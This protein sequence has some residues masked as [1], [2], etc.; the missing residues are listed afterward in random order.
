LPPESAS[1]RNPYREWIGAQ[2]RADFFGYITPDDPK[3]GAELAWRDASISHV[4]NGIYG[5]MFVAAML[6]ASYVKKD[7]EDII[8]TGMSQIPEK[9][10]L[11]E[12]IKIVLDWR[13]EGITWEDAINR[14]HEKYDEKNM[15]H[16]THTISN[17]I[18]VCI[19][20]LYGECD[21]EKSIG[22][23]VTAG[24][25]TDCNCATVGSIIGFVLGSKALPEKWTNPLNNRLKSGGILYFTRGSKILLALS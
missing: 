20:L 12:G 14:V 24:F 4:K 21:F 10:R 7:I 6:S 1:Y 15:H 8:R 17:A 18:I 9:S 16:W 5:E 3:K 19:G 2:I 23:A 13:K 25:D 22:I 11:Y